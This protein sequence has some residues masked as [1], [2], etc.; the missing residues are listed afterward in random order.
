MNGAAEVKETAAL[1]LG[2]VIAVTGS[3]ALKPSVLNI[4]G[5]LI[6]ILGDRFA[7]TL[8]VALLDTLSMLLE[9][10]R[11]WSSNETEH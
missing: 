3:D 1:G 5:P 7:W 4:A 2:E 6:R 10:V 11:H 9:K 8:K